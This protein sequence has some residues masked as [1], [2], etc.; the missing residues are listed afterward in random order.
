MLYHVPN[1]TAET[2]VIEFNFIK[3]MKRGKNNY[4]TDFVEKAAPRLFAL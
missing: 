4:T 2:K 3:H 1:Q